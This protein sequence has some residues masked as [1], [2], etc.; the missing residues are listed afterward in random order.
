MAAPGYHEPV[1]PDESIRALD[2]REEGSY[3]D[4]TFGGGGHAR[5]ILGALGPTGRLLAFDQDAAAGAN[6]PDDARLTFVPHNFRHLARFAGFYAFKQVDGILADLGV[7]SHQ[8]DQ[9]ERGFSYRF[10]DELLDM[11]MDRQHSVS[12]AE[13]LNSWAPAALQAMFSEYGEVRNAR[14][15]A[16]ELVR[17]RAGRP[18]RRVG[19]LL[20]VLEPLVRGDRHRYLAQVFQ[21]LRIAVNDELGAL[22]EMLEATTDLLRPGGRLVVLTYHSLEDRIV[23]RFMRDGNVRGEADKDWYGNINRPFRVITKD[24]VTATTEE[25]QRNPRSHSAKLRVAEKQ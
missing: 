21:A 11:R 13:I 15:L 14:T 6:I 19:D 25:L 20:E 10:P 12:A 22:A 18:Y 1:L 9:P 8:L 24:P 7:S 2:L 23:K 17:H 16:G 5:M 3:V 4:V